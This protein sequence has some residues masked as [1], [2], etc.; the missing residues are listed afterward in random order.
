MRNLPAGGTSHGINRGPL[1]ANGKPSGSQLPKGP[2]TGTKPVTSTRGSVEPKVIANQFDG[3]NLATSSCGCQPPDVNATIGPN[4]IVE[5]VNLSIAVYTK[6]G[7]QLSNIALSTFLGTGDSLSD[8]RVLYDPT[9][10][11][12]SLVLTDVTTPTLWTAFSAT[13]DPMG[14]WWIYNF[15][16][17]GVPSGGVADYP[18]VGM[19]QDAYI[20]TTNNFSSTSYLNTTA[21]ALAKARVYN[22]FGWSASVFG[23]LPPTTTPSILGGHPSQQDYRLFLLSPNDGA[24]VMAV[25][26][27]VN[28]EQMLAGNGTKLK[29]K[30][31]VA[32]NWAAPPRRVNQPGTGQTLDPLD[33]RIVWAVSQLDGRLWFAHG[34]AVGSF[35]GVNWGYVNPNSMSIFVSTA[36]H[37][38]SSDDFNP[39]IAAQQHGAATQEVLT[40]AYTDTPNNVPTTDVYEIHKGFSIVHI[41]GDP[42]SSGGGS[43]SEFRFG[44][45]AS[46][47]P[48]Y[49]AVGTCNEGTYALVANQYFDPSNGQWRTRLARVRSSCP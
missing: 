19:N 42:F 13:S 7:T 18:I 9:W 34:T 38:G 43:T 39:A 12:Y 33:G 49:N 37:S 41:A 25:W 29:F 32:Y 10:D 48:E 45:Y 14:G 1:L 35:P 5:A 8:P 23:G 6:T 3:V 46:V 2:S 36:F 21:F 28:P 22:G 40:W 20:Y 15:G 26:Y 16:I 44:D 47:A 4:H 11:R 30:G 24:N 27:M 17:P 31:N